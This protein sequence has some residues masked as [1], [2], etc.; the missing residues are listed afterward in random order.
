MYGMLIYQARKNRKALEDAIE[1]SVREARIASNREAQLQEAKENLDVALRVASGG[2]RFTGARFRSLRAFEEI[3]G[4]GDDGRRTPS[5]DDAEPRAAVKLIHGGVLADPDIAQR[6]SR[7]RRRIAT[8]ISGPNLVQ[9]REVGTSAD[10]SPFIAMELLLGEDLRSA[11]T[12]STITLDEARD[13]VVDV[14]QG[15][16]ILHAEGIVHRDLKPSNLFHAEYKDHRSSWKILD[17]GVSKIRTSHGT[18]TEGR[19]VG[20]P[21]YMSPEQAQ[22]RTCDA[23]ADIFSLGAVLYRALTGRRPFA[24]S[25][26]PQTLFHVVYVQ[27]PRPREIVPDL[28]RD[29]ESVLA[30]ALSK[31]PA[32]R[33]GTAEELARA[34]LSA[35]KGISPRPI[36]VVRSVVLL[37]FR[38]ARARCRGRP[39]REATRHGQHEI[40]LFLPR[41]SRRAIS[42][43]SSPRRRAFDP[44]RTR[45]LAR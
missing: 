41:E 7:A 38:G 18:L 37:I 31:R 15:L 1:R 45:D 20:T 9:V 40:G 26:V 29:V 4:R 36:A 6:F 12:K 13:L 27:P 32:D 43:R 44:R 24:G 8:E 2:G 42:A 22:G 33:F 21:G 25:D 23:G 11:R 19:L 14:S 35:S 16:A 39:R 5:R 3:V 17:Y 28:P 30:L 34:F 10:G